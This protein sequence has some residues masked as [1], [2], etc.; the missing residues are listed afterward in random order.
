MRSNTRL[1]PLRSLSVF[2]CVGR[3]QSFRA[4]SEELCITQSA[5]SYHIK[6]LEQSLGVK[7][8]ERHARGIAFRPEGRAYFDLIRQT[9]LR[10]EDGTVAIRGTSAP[11]KLRVSVLPAFAANWLVRR[12]QRFN[13]MHPDIEVL[14]DSALALADLNRGEADLSIRYGFGDWPGVRTEQVL[15]E[16]LCPVASPAYL[17]RSGRIQK[18]ADVL[19]HPLLHVSRPEEWNLWAAARGISLQGARVHQLT[20]YNVVQQAVVEGMGIAMGRRFLIEDRI[21]AGALTQLFDDWLQPE[22][23]GYWI[24]LPAHR[25]KSAARV[26]AGWLLEE[27]RKDGEAV[28]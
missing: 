7:V 6:S 28:R 16:Q 20:D 21:A 27:A 8:F 10:L 14:L 17:E 11:V 13:E 2:E 25:D 22:S 19:R 24:C 3:L 5:V 23:L 4:A 9:F 26:F 1:P 18:P 12:L 15:A